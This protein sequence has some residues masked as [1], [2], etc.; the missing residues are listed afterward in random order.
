MDPLT[1]WQERRA[2]LA[3][4]RR[5]KLRVKNRKTGQ[6]TVLPVE[7]WARTLRAWGWDLLRCTI[8]WEGR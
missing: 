6:V 3:Q 1:A 5:R 2:A 7:G 4:K 8:E